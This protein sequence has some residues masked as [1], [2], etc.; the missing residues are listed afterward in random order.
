MRLLWSTRATV[1]FLTRHT[2]VFETVQASLADAVRGTIG[3][4]WRG[5]GQRALMLDVD[6]TKCIRLAIRAFEIIENTVKPSEA[7]F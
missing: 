1:L 6:E 5:G 3:P 2:A 7:V 4:S